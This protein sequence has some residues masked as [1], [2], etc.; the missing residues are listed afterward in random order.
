MNRIGL[1][2]EEVLKTIE[3]ETKKNTLTKKQVKTK[4]KKIAETS[5][6]IKPTNTRISLSNRLSAKFSNSKPKKLTFQLLKNK[7][8]SSDKVA[9]LD[10]VENE[11]FFDADKVIGSMQDFNCASPKPSQFK[12]KTIS[13]GSTNTISRLSLPINQQ[14]YTNQSLK[15]FDAAQKEN[16]EGHTYKSSTKRLFSLIT[17]VAGGSGSNAAHNSLKLNQVKQSHELFHLNQQR[18]LSDFHRPTKV[19]FKII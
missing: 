1:P 14:N 10:P 12:A 18:R 19:S 5:E 4:D 16:P 2:D 15:S 8:E 13:A 7:P 6:P 9:G 3:I 11:D 17:S